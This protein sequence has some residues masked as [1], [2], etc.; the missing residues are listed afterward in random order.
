MQRSDVAVQPRGSSGAGRRRSAAAASETCPDL[1]SG[2]NGAGDQ[3]EKKPQIQAIQR[4]H[5]LPDRPIGN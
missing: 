3:V 4:A 5:V 1:G 2:P